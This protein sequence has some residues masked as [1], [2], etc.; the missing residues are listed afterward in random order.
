MENTIP[1]EEFK[2]VELRT[3]RIVSAE[4]VP[5]SDKLLKLIL[6]DGS[7]D[8]PAGR[9]VIAGIG[10]AY[11]PESLLGRNVVIVANLAPR[12]LMGLESQAMILASSGDEFFSLLKMDSPPGSRVK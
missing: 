8:L 10:K 11:Q 12:S 5:G 9:Q 1:F 7:A 2:K 3:A 6:D 4:R